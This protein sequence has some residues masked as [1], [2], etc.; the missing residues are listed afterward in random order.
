LKISGGFISFLPLIGELT[1]RKRDQKLRTN[2]IAKI[3]RN[4]AVEYVIG[5]IGSS[6][7]TTA[8]YICKSFAAM[9]KVDDVTGAASVL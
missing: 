3:N 9:R 6:K 1:L 7:A 5:H 8:L 2:I 4:V